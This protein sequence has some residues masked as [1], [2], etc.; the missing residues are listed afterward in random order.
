MYLV[1][2]FLICFASLF[3]EQCSL[4]VSA[5]YCILYKQFPYNTVCHIAREEQADR[6][7]EI[8]RERERICE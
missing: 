3:K 5:L 1:P 2:F 6:D 8:Q 7:E 4:K